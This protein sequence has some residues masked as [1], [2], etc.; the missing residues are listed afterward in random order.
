MSISY[1]RNSMNWALMVAMVLCAGALAR[2][3]DQDRQEDK[4][5]KI[6]K[7]DQDHSKPNLGPSDRDQSEQE[8]PKYWIGLLG[9]P[10]PPDHVLRAQLDL[11]ANQGLLVA[12]V[13]PNSPATKAGL[14]QY[15]VLVKA[16]D[17]ELHEMK[18]LVDLVLSE[19]AKKGQISLDVLRR[20]KHETIAL[21]PEERPANVTTPQFGRD[22]DEG[23]SGGPDVDQFM[24]QFRKRLPMQFRNMGP[25]VI[26][27]GGGGVAN[28]PNGV[29]ISVHKENDKPAHISVK[30]GS[31]SWE[32]DGD[33]DESLKK[34]PADLRPFVEQMLHGGGIQ[35][36]L[37]FNVPG[38]G[39]GRGPD[40]DAGRMSER[41][42]RMEKRLEEMQKRMLSP[43]NQPEN[44]QNEKAQSK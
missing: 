4:V 43:K 33:D 30:R 25:G 32:I 17:K 3:Q 27:G 40:M 36:P 2:A 44:S 15:D 10:I 34:L 8:A 22:Q 13:L 23:M 37:P 7:S 31:D 38:V 9:G 5:I 14:K 16:N 41:L 29:S 6:G 28:M 24:Q 35:G 20:G 19:G 42:E 12:N 26:V 18:D 11:P 21:K 39:P 1:L